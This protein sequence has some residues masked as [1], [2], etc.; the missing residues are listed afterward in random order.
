MITRCICLLAG[1]YSLEFLPRIP[2]DPA[3]AGCLLLSALFAAVRPLRPAAFYLGG[4]CLMS[5]AASKVLEEKLDHRLQGQA[6]TIEG[7]IADFPQHI[8]DAVRFEFAPLA[9]AGV[10][11]RIRLAWYEA[12]VTPRLGEHWR[13]EV[14]LRRPRGYANPD[15]FDYAGWLFRQRIGAT[16]YVLGELHNYR[17]HGAPV[18]VLDR[19]RR[20][21]VERI[22]ATL[23]A[24]N[25]TAVLMAIAVGAR[26]DIDRQHWDLYAATG[27]THL[28]A[29]SGLH[30]GLAA[31]SAF[32]VCWGV[33][34]LL[35][36][37][38]NVRDVALCGGVLAAG[39]Y[40]LLSGFAV[41]AQRA[42]LMTV[43]AGSMLLIRRRI[44]PFRLLALT[45]ILVFA[46]DPLALLAPGFKL[47]FAAVAVL[48]LASRPLMIARSGLSAPLGDTMLRA[49]CRIVT[50][51]VALLGGLFA[52][53]V[54]EFDRVSLAAPFVNLA[55]LPIFNFFTVPLTLA[56]VL[57]D[58]VFQPLGNALLGF[59]HRSITWV[60]K[61]VEFFSRLDF[62]SVRTAAPAR[63]WPLLLPAALVLLPPGWPGRRVAAI[64]V[65]AVIDFKPAP[66]EPDCFEVHVLDVGQGLAVVVR[67]HAH[68]LLFDTG[69]AF[70]GGGDS[71]Q[72]VV[73]PFLRS[74][75]VG[76]LQKVLLSHADLDHAGGI[77]SIVEALPVVQVLVGEPLPASLVAQQPCVA[78]DRWTWD[79]VSFVVLHPRRDSPW[80]GND[81]SCVLEISS[82]D[83]RVLLTGDIEAPVEQLLRHNGVFNPSHAVVVPHHG[84]R[85]SSTPALVDAT[86]PR[87]AIVSAGHDNRWGFPKQEVIERWQRSGAV[88]LNTATD[89]A[90]SQSFCRDTGA[91]TVDLARPRRMK[92]WHDAST[93]TS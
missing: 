9:R 93:D 29:I 45:A 1:A 92:Y 66:P 18:P 11:P 90:V 89:G 33:S 41:P 64:A 13:L 40:A 58:G 77:G 37:R 10:P 25:A 39:A 35:T 38:R 42:L 6:I 30:V 70:R 20:H 55:V 61:I 63:L 69:P 54:L 82:G 80:R 5:M 32:L 74:R 91:G 57:L 4:F 8:G 24:G 56:G 28:M 84:S 83:H 31:G 14:R 47:S 75:G 26:Q 73:L 65:L 21:V 34:S 3:L 7:R 86:R 44:R 87:L 22:R 49:G 12:A 88:L 52:L 17:M 51:Q 15:G 78:G 71:A 48:F 16:G 27:T 23:P 81:A 50:L 60:L 79:G 36:R 72:L 68:A 85:T 76:E 2:A 67:T 59:A 46:I 53:S 43:I 19:L 62:L